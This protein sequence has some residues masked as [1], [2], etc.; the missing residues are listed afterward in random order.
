MARSVHYLKLYLVNVNWVSVLGE[1]ENLPHLHGIRFG[2]T[3]SR[4]VESSSFRDTFLVLLSF[5]SGVN[6]GKFSWCGRTLVSVEAGATTSNFITCPVVRES[7]GKKSFPGTPPPKGSSG[8]SS[9]RQKTA[10]R[11]MRQRQL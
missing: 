1:V 5:S 4:T 2:P 8:P 6:V 11:S 9:I 7:A 10:F 3:P